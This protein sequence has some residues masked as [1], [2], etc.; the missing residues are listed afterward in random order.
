MKL[1]CVKRDWRDFPDKFCTTYQQNCCQPVINSDSVDDWSLR[2]LLLSKTYVLMHT[3]QW[4][5]LAQYQWLMCQY[6][7]IIKRVS[8]SLS[9]NSVTCISTHHS[10]RAREFLDDQCASIEELL[11]NRK[12]VLICTGHW[13]QLAQWPVC[14]YT[15]IIMRVYLNDW[16]VDSLNGWFISTHCSLRE[17]FLMNGV[18]QHT[19]HWEQLY[20]CVFIYTGEQKSG[21]SK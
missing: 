17:A 19:G 3:I 13:Q 15:P 16:F 9:M 6:K 1:G 10:L 14:W 18:H 2:D 4:Q 5:Q 8:D 20:W 11:L 21:R 12:Y 7:P